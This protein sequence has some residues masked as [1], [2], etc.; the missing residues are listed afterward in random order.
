MLTLIADSGSTKTQ[1]RVIDASGTTTHDFTTPG[2]NPA[3]M[4]ASAVDFG[5]STALR[6]RRIQPG[7]VFYYG[8]GCTPERIFVVR[9]AL[10][11]L[12]PKA[13]IHV[14]SDLVAAVRAL[15]AD[16]EGIV[17]ILGTGMASC[18]CGGGE[19]VCQTPSLGYVLGDEGSGAV[20]GRRMVS[21]ILKGALPEKVCQA[22]KEEFGLSAADV[23]D[24][25]YRQPQANRFLSS[26]MP[27]VA[28]Q[29]SVPEV[30]EILVD[31]FRTFFRRNVVPYHRP[32]LSVHFVGSVATHFQD[33]IAEA[34]AVEGFTMGAI[35]Q[36]PM[37]KLAAYHAAR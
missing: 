16:D 20:L 22:W 26:F 27:F 4:P 15:C 12:Y 10:S 14:E 19:I 17:C 31:E 30:R 21:A 5:I 29:R 1:W 24:R 2:L 11:R 18:L 33:E 37:D 36:A 13:E 23:I 6:K 35:L 34:A 9:G 25:V 8:A 32:D 7:R 3:L 28:Q